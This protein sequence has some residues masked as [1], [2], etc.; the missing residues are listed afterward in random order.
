MNESGRAPGGSLSLLFVFDVPS[1]IVNRIPVYTVQSLA[2]SENR[3]MDTQSGQMFFVIRLLPDTDLRQ[4][5]EDCAKKWQVQAAVLVTMVGS[6]KQA[7]LRLAGADEPASFE[8]PLEIVSVTGTISCP[9]GIHV[10]ISVA[11]KGGV[12]YGGHLVYGC[13]VGT[14]VELT[15]LN[16]SDS[17]HFERRPDS[18]TG[19]KELIA[20]PRDANKSSGA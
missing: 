15:I 2:E 11:D 10:H 7:K 14:T 20:T 5:I 13:T 19:Y 8:G 6:L 18:M 1:S 17:F 9:C 16:R 3:C 4:G 12:V